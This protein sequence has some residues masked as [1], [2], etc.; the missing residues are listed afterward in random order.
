MIPTTLTMGRAYSEHAMEAAFGRLPSKSDGTSRFVVADDC[1]VGLLPVG[2]P[3]SWFNP[4]VH[5]SHSFFL[6]PDRIYWVPDQAMKTGQSKDVVTEIDH[7]LH[8]K[9][10]L[11]LLIR[12]TG[13]Q[14]W[15]RAIASLDP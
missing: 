2:P 4:G 5:C 7:L 3:P 9:A 15:R 8:Q 10:D 6:A 14:E 11:H 12:Y 1:I 13:S